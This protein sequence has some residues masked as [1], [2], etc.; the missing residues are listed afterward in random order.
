MSKREKI[1]S[2]VIV[3]MV[4]ILI[5]GSINYFKGNKTPEVAES[6]F[7]TAAKLKRAQTRLL[8]KETFL[9]IINNVNISDEAKETAVNG[10]I[11]L[12]AIAVKEDATETLLI[13][14]GFSD[15]VVSIIDNKI[16]VIIN[17]ASLTMLDLSEI[18]DIIKRLT[19]IEAHNIV[20]STV[21]MEE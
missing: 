17:T 6:N 5:V 20:I 1:Q 8:N 11:N 4:F 19:G 15:A 7:F 18:Q 13:A 2:I 12:T 21:V 3:I 10:L 14:K 9:D 16:D